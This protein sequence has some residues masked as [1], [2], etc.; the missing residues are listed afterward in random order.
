MGRRGFLLTLAA[1]ALAALFG[2]PVGAIP[3]GDDWVVVDGWIARRS[4]VGARETRPAR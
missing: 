4:Q 3:R 1:G 2:R